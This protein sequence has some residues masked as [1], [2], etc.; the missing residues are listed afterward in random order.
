MKALS[1]LLAL[2]TGLAFADSLDTGGGGI[3]GKVTQQNLATDSDLQLS[4]IPATEFE[5]VDTTSDEVTSDLTDKLSGAGLEPDQIK[6]VIE[7]LKENNQ[8]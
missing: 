8:L 7:A 5:A 4:R 1:C 3:R 2:S 6:T